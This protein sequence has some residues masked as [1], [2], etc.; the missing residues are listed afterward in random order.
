MTM[1]ATSRMTRQVLVH[2]TL[3][4]LAGLALLELVG[5][6]GRAWAMKASK[7]EVAYR[8]KPHGAQ[9]CATCRQF[10]AIGS[11]KGLCSI[12]D[13]DVSPLGWCTAYSARGSQTLGAA[14]LSEPAPVRT[15]D[16]RHVAVPRTAHTEEGV[17]T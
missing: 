8:D 17:H 1:P 16:V 2:G 13:G 12:V 7:D 10:T 5:R 15:V 3:R 11:G 4:L 9:S 14:A 6:P